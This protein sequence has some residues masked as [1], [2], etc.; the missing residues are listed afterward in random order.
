MGWLLFEELLGL[1]GASLVLAE[2][3]GVEE[4]LAAAGELA[5]SGNGPATAPWSVVLGCD[6][7][8]LSLVQA[9]RANK[10]H[11]GMRRNF[12]IC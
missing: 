3:A 5:G 9:L 6:S 4:V 8:V 7:V 1:A 12:F 11:A 10:A 2:L